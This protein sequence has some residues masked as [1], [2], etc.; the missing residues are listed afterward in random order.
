MLEKFLEYYFTFT[1]IFFASC[2]FTE[3]IDMNYNYKKIG[4]QNKEEI[5]KL[6]KKYYPTVLYNLFV[7]S[8]P[9]IFF[10]VNFLPIP[11]YN[12]TSYP[13]MLGELIC[14]KVL[15][16]ATFYTTHRILHT[17]DLYQFHKK[18]HEVTNPIGISAIYMS[19][20]DLYFSNLIPI[21]W[22]PLLVITSSLT[23]KLWIAIS[24]II[25]I[26]M[27]HG[28]FKDLSEFHDLHHTY[29]KCNYGNNMFMDKLFNTIYK[30]RKLDKATNTKNTTTVKR[31]KNKVIML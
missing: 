27:A 7:L 17:K 19:G 2:K 24:I 10:T 1:T 20:V 8:A 30:N 15:V 6:Y 21:T 28:G 4:L 23:Y 16:D 13:H 26:Y 14:T 9:F 5:A 18:H 22:T 25:T 11:D 29:P 31:Y 3:Y 12:E